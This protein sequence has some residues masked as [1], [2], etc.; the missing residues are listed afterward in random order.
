MKNR[1]GS[2]PARDT[3]PSARLPWH[4]AGIDGL[5]ATMQA[6]VTQVVT[7][8]DESEES[9]WCV[10]SARGFGGRSP[11]VNHTRGVSRDSVRAAP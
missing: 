4:L 1:E 2:T 7:P 3:T 6:I 10:E 5:T 9:G 11:L 8:S